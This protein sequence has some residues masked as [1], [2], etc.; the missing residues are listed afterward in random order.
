MGS[1]VSKKMVE[2]ET[3]FISMDSLIA[4]EKRSRDLQAF[5]EHMDR[6]IEAHHQQQQ[7][8]RGHEEKPENAGN[9]FK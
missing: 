2:V 6:L 7:Q 9:P 8:E 5:H 1:C 3:E 4:A